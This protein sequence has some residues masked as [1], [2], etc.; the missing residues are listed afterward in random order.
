MLPFIAA[1]LVLIQ[2]P[3]T[4]TT[5]RPIDTGTQTAAPV[6]RKMAVL[7]WCLKDGTDTAN[8][9]ARDTIHKLFEGVNYEVVP[10]VQAK[11]IWEE[12][13]GYTPVKLVS[14]GSDNYPDLPTAKQL[15]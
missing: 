6:I 4:S 12:Q 1:A 14:N 13:L 8:D 10:E 11:S 7:P 5:P 15:L 2:Q 9:V 3:T